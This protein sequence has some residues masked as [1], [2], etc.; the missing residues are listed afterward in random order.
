MDVC[1]SSVL[2]RR[3]RSSFFANWDGELLHDELSDEG[4]VLDVRQRLSSFEISRIWNAP[5]R[6]LSALSRCLCTTSTQARR[7][8]DTS[9]GAVPDERSMRS[10]CNT[11]SALLYIVEA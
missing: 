6:C 2:S 4:V 10:S 1:K 11:Q 9:N 8:Q 5:S 7:I 3:A